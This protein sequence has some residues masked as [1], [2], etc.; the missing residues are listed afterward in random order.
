MDSLNNIYHVTVG[1]P[2][3]RYVATVPSAV[4]GRRMSMDGSSETAFIICSPD[5]KFSYDTSV[6]EIYTAREDAYLKQRNKGLFAQGLLAEFSGAAPVAE[7]DGSLTDAQIL[8]IATITNVATLGKR[9]QDV[10]NYV[11]AS[12]ILS[13]AKEVGRP[14]KTLA[15]IQKRVDELR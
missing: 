8:E 5:G 10:T 14:E 4:G 15:L 13:A 12:R 9:L 11:N 7:T 1:E 6:L 2:Y 3:K